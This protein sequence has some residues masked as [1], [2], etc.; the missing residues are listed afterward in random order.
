MT[1][2]KNRVILHSIVESGDCKNAGGYIHLHSLYVSPY[3]TI[4]ECHFK[5]GDN[6]HAVGSSLYP[7]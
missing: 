3:K 1:I 4:E 2:V 6:I 7:K 5:K